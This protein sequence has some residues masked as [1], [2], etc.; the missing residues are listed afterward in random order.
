MS[1]WPPVFQKGPI[2]GMHA[3][4]GLALDM[5]GV[6]ADDPNI[7]QCVKKWALASLLRLH[8][9]GIGQCSEKLDVAI[10]RAAAEFASIGRTR[11]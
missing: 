9:D 6:R 8:S 4:E 7:P 11:Q 2:P 1:M 5:F 3:I 10:A